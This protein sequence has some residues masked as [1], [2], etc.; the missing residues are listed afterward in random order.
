M[1]ASDTPNSGEG[2]LSQADSYLPGIEDVPQ[3]QLLV[4]DEGI[5]SQV[6]EGH[7]IVRESF[8]IP[9]TQRDTRD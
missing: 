9:A 8:F 1:P 2:L 5:F 6:I 7:V 3:P 4:I